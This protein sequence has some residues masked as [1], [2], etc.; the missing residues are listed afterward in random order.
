ML[1]WC[2]IAH[3]EVRALALAL[4][5]QRTEAMDI[6]SNVEGTSNKLLNLLSAGDRQLMRN[7]MTA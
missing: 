5:R 6:R 1:P 7:E 4:V 3:K 2:D